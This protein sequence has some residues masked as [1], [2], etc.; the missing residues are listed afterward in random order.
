LPNLPT[1]QAGDAPISLDALVLTLARGNVTGIVRRGDLR[2]DL[3]LHGNSLVSLTLQSSDRTI[4]GLTASTAADGTFTLRDVPVT[5]SDED[6]LFS[7]VREDYAGV[8]ARTAVAAGAVAVINADANGVAVPL[9]LES[10]LRA[11]D[12]CAPTGDCV[13]ASF[14]NTSSVRIEISNDAN[15]AAVRVRAGTSFNATDPLP[16]FVDY[17]ALADLLVDIGSVDGPVEIFLQVRDDD[18]AVGDVARVGVVRD[19]VPPALVS[20]DRVLSSGAID[21]RFTRFNVVDLDV[22]GDAGVGNVAPLGANRVAFFADGDVPALAPPADATTCVPGA[23]CRV[24]LPGAA[25]PRTARSRSCS[26]P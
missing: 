23:N 8:T 17:D 13:P 12:V 11:F 6:Y 14:F 21:A 3:T 20:V 19:T 7:A 15:V 22:V 18:G 16:P 10:D 24:A 5:R 25:G 1:Q 2:D 26:A 9:F 4:E